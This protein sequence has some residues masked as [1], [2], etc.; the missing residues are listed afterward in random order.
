MYMD[1]F[2]SRF[3]WRNR[4]SCIHWR[5]TLLHSLDASYGEKPGFCPVRALLRMYS[6]TDI[7]SVVDR[8]LLYSHTAET[9]DIRYG[10]IR[11]IQL[12]PNDK[13]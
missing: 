12:G 5:C 1:D 13:Y 2:W 8:C 10:W 9:Q 3:L 7:R 4:K 11:A 6:E